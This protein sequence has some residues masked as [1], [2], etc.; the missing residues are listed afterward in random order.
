MTLRRRRSSR[1]CT[2]GG[3][4]CEQLQ[5]R[6]AT[7]GT[8]SSRLDPRPISCGAQPPPPVI[9]SPLREVFAHEGASSPAEFGASQVGAGTS[10]ESGGRTRCV[11]AELFGLPGLGK[12]TLVRAL[13]TRFRNR[14]RPIL[15]LPEAVPYAVQVRGIALVDLE[16]FLD[17]VNAQADDLARQMAGDAVRAMASLV[18]ARD[19]GHQQNESYRYVL[20]ALRDPSDGV[21]GALRALG[22]TASH[23]GWSE[24]LATEVGERLWDRHAALR[25]APA[26]PWQIAHVV[27]TTGDPAHD[28]ALSLRRQRNA[29]RDPRLV[30]SDPVVLA[31][32]LATLRYVEN[33][34]RESSD[35]SMV[36]IDPTAPLNEAASAVERALQRLA[37]ASTAAAP[38]LRL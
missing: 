14:G 4:V 34:T 5:S 37:V 2:R 1:P 18:V 15:V 27:L 19:P 20:H 25:A 28:F 6:G 13:S 3:G 30:T 26:G 36:V 24:V 7:V 17:A 33:A 31:G 38:G 29:D 11:R 35:V 10:T 32:Y 8:P 12:S 9:P 23:G 21:A 22:R 16:P